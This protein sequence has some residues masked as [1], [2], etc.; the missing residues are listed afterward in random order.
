MSPCVP[1]PGQWWNQALAAF[2]AYIEPSAA[3]TDASE[4]EDEGEKEI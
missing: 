4:A 1:A 2:K 3:D